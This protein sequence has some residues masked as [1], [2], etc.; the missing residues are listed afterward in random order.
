MTI[1]A[2]D[3]PPNKA[4]YRAIADAIAASVRDGELSPGDRLPTHRDLADRLGGTVGTVSRGYAEAERRGLVVGE[5]GRGTFVRGER[6]GDAWP[7]P[8][9]PGEVIDLSLSLP[10]RVPEEGPLLADTL[11]QLAAD[12]ALGELLT[13]RSQTATPEQL[14]VVC[15][16]LLEV[17]IRARPSDVLVTAGSQHSLNIAFSALF[18][19]GSVVLAGALTYPS[20]KAITRTSGLRLRGVA[21]DEGGMCPDAAL[22]ACR[23]E[24]KPR[25]LYIV[26]TLQNPTSATLSIERRRAFAELAESEDLWIIE[27]DIHARLPP[28]PDTPIASLAPHR[29]VYLSSVAKS[30]VPGLRTG[31]LAAPERVH[32]RLLAAIH[33]SVWMPPPLMVEVTCRWLR[34]GTAHRLLAAKR[35][36]TARRQRLAQEILA[37]H[38]LRADPHGYQVW[39]ELPEPWHADEFVASARKRGVIVV[40]GGAFAIGRSNIPQAV[41]LSLGQPNITDLKVGLSIIDEL[42]QTGGV[43]SY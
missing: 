34:D 15:A 2:P 13:Y 22:R 36:E 23:Q 1:W 32:P 37:R 11:G 31:F 14:D 26:P 33:A 7:A 20:I 4:R 24:P 3:L 30:L 35:R 21:I 25:G 16:W 12:P 18:P 41:R 17:G 39:I 10:A 5:V 19:R 8:V 42:L 27:D 9:G 28:E 6:T 43:P 38:T 40:G 29:T